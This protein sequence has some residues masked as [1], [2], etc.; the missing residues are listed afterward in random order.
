MDFQTADGYRRSAEERR[1]IQQKRYV[2]GYGEI[3]NTDPVVYPV[4][5]VDRLID[6]YL[7][8]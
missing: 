5:K 7:K 4:L 6:I 1:K 2:C 8:L 3:H